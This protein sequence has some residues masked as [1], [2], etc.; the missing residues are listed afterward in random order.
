MKTE[1][2][3]DEALKQLKECSRNLFL[4]G[5]GGTGKSTLIKE[6]V[7]LTEDAVLLAASTGTA[8]VNIGGETCHRMF[9]IPIPSAGARVTSRQDGA[10]KIL[11]K[12]DTV[13]IDEVSMLSNADF[14]FIWRVMKKAGVVRGKKIR[15]I[16]TGDLLQ[17]P[18]VV[19]KQTK[20][21][22]KK[23]G[24]DESGWCFAC[25]EW[26]DAH[27]KTI[28]LT[29][30]MRQTDKDYISHLNNIRQGI[31]DI[32]WSEKRIVKKERIPDDCI[33]ICG[34]NAEADYINN[35]RLSALNGTLIA[36]QADRQG[37]VAQPPAD[38]ILTLKVGERVMFTVNSMIPGQY[39]NGLMGTVTACHDDNVRVMADTGT[40]I[41]VY[42][43]LWHIYSYKTAGGAITRNETGTFRQIPLKPAYAIT[44]HKSQGKTFDRAVISPETFAAGQLYVALSRV[45]SEKGLCL[46]GNIL[47]E[48]IITDDKVMDFINNDYTY[49]L[50]ERKSIKKADKK[51]SSSPRKTGKKT[52][53]TAGRRKT[54]RPAA[55]RRAG[56]NVSK[57]TRRRKT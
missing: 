26:N 28:G 52:H 48:Y 20:A 29:E 31:P 38:E 43:Y 25:R 12:A 56:K 19:T 34:T 24:F 1:Y 51:K 36:Y 9:S 18:P 8:A 7:S 47:P 11:S 17:L 42:P 50:P 2:T 49:E 33:Y 54:K 13:I 14:S 27:F 57:T 6:Y 23:A 37:R 35:E 32:S 45:K 41:T 16:I 44:I 53:K 55:K 40:E 21:L 3:Y 15:L 46:T 5:P 4:T 22:L 30:I 39:Q 10:V